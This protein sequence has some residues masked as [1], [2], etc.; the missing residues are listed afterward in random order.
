MPGQ[1][2]IY[3]TFLVSADGGGG[4]GGWGGMGGGGD[5]GGLLDGLK[6]AG[7]MELFTILSFPHVLH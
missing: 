3:E 2:S 4:V 7:L 6:E 1:K 5:E